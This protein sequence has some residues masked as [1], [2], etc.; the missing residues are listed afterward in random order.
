M[1]SPEPIAPIQVDLARAMGIGTALWGAGLVV[2]VVLAALGRIS[3]TPA[4]VCTVGALLGF[5]GVW[6]S[7]QHDT[8][9]RRLKR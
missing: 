3:W 2:T 5:A 1:T 7:H 4:A 9:G 8:M 6:W